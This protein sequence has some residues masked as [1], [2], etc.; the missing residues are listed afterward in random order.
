MFLYLIKCQLNSI[1]GL[2]VANKNFNIKYVNSKIADKIHL[3]AKMDVL[4]ILKLNS[5]NI[6][7]Y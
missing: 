6:Y 1:E 2:V 4:L 5:E 7:H 3:H